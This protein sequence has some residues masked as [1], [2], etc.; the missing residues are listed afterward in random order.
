ML[1]RNRQ[2]SEP[3]Q[4]IIAGNAALGER[5]MAKHA[6][7][8]GIVTAA[9][10]GRGVEKQRASLAAQTGLAVLGYALDSWF[11]DPSLR[12]ADYLDHGFA[13]LQTLALNK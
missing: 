3:R 8:V 7:L 9:L 10:Q 1:E 13:E 2:Y 5:E 11:A 4:R 6:A 12:L